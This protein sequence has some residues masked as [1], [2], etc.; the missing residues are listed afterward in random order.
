[1]SVIYEVNL[2]VDPDI[3]EAYAAWLCPHMDAM[4]ELEGF[5]SVR[6]FV[7]EPDIEA[8]E[9]GWLLWSIQYG[10][11]SRE[12]LEAYFRDG[13]ARMRGDGLERFGGRFEASRRILAERA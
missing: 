2:S 12:A 9:R 6:W 11:S 1:M 13:A 7:R 10:V 4:L 5:E 8:D 3:A